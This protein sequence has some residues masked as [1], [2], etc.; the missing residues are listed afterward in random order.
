MKD[1]IEELILYD[2][3]KMD[4]VMVFDVILNVLVILL[5]GC[6]GLIFNFK[7]GFLLVL[8]LVLLLN[9]GFYVFYF[10]FLEERIVFELECYN[11]VFDYYMVGRDKKV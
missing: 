1:E 8:L 3:Y 6:F 10:G 5:D 2:F 9:I 4:C 7:V 11:E